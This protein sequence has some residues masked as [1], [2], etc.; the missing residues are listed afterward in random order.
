MSS[1]KQYTLQELSLSWNSTTTE[2]ITK[3]A[4]ALT[5]NTG[6][7]TLD[8]SS[9]H[10][11]D[12]V[13]F[14]MTLLTAMEHNHTIVRLVLPLN[15]IKYINEAMISKVNEGRSNKLTL[16]IIP[17]NQDRIYIFYHSPDDVHSFTH[18]H[19]QGSIINIVMHTVDEEYEQI[20]RSILRLATQ[21]FQRPIQRFQRPIKRFQRRYQVLRDVPWLR[22]RA[23]RYRSR[24]KKFHSHKFV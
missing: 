4:K 19:P 9:Q 10:V 15:V 24:I 5:V 23:I 16:D 7:R 22:V 18:I 12:P 8:L 13:H 2:G 17:C 14:T 11:N 1:N 20:S 3:I 21:R 6:L